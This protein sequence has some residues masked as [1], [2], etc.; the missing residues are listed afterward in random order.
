M[1]TLSGENG[2]LENAGLGENAGSG[3]NGEPVV[4][5][6]VGEE[7]RGSRRVVNLGRLTM[8]T[9]GTHARGGL[10]GDLR[11]FA[12]EVEEVPLQVQQPLLQSGGLRRSPAARAHH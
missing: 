10:G 12:I 6:W 3:E 2:D 7:V 1:K 9:P 5:G 8:Q 4:E 11:R